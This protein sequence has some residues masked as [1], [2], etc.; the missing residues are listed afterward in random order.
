ME[1]GDPI[2]HIGADDLPQS[3][4]LL[5]EGVGVHRGLLVHGLEEN[6]FDGYGVGELFPQPVLVKQ[7][8][9]LDADL[10]ILVRVEG[11]NAALGGAKGVAPQTF[12][13]IGILENVIGHEQLGPLGDDQVGGGYPG[14][15]QTG[16]L[17]GQLL[18]VQGHA[19]AD[20]IG[21][22]GVEHARGQGVQG[23]AAMV[24]DDGVA[25]VGPALE[26]DDD[27]RMLRHQI[28]DLSFALRRP[29]W[30]LRSLLPQRSPPK[31]ISS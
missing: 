20:D 7:V 18:D 25:G 13:L 27:V 14:L 11:G 31:I 23:K 16:E 4:Q 2:P 15:D 26:P 3:Q 6:V 10:G 30:R 24:V 21:D 28:R 17:V 1:E 29:S 5:E 19:V 9:D 22:V 12:L 8:A